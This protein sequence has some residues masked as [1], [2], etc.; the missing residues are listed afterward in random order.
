MEKINYTI[1]VPNDTDIESVIIKFKRKGNE[2]DL[3]GGP[4]GAK[5]ETFVLKKRPSDEEPDEG[6]L[7]DELY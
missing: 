4:K 6:L 7:F 3:K 2:G 1:I 5:R